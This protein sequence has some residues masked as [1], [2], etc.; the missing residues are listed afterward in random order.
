MAQTFPLLTASLLEERPEG[1]PLP[2]F[3]RLRMG[4]GRSRTSGFRFHPSRSIQNDGVHD[5]PN[6]PG[7]AGY[8]LNC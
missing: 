1:M 3:V 5:W 4:T 8:H 6:K 2:D 7:P